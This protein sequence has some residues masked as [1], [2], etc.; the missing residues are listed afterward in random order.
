MALRRGLYDVVK[1]SL[2]GSIIGN[3]LLVMGAAILAGGLKFR[4]QTFNASGARVQATMLTLAAV[5]LVVPAA[6]HYLSGPAGIVREAG[7]SFDISI[8]LLLTYALSLLFSLHTHKQLFAG[9]TASSAC[10]GE[11]QKWVMEPGTFDRHPD[12]RYRPDRMDQRDPGGV[13][14]SGSTRLRHVEHLRRGHHRCHCRECGRTQY[15]HS[16]GHEEPH[17]PEF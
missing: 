14:G 6:F 3:V 5:G 9:H 11:R 4:T 1:A 12:A 2:T 7:L 17:G 8:V 10:R 15:R 13:R 16:G